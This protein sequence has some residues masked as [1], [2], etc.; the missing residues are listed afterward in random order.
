MRIV[1][2][3][4]FVL[5]CCA[6]FAS[7]SKAQSKPLTAQDRAAY[8]NSGLSS[9]QGSTQAQREDFLR[10]ESE[11]HPYSYR[12]TKEYKA[13]SP[14]QRR[15]MEQAQ[16]RNRAALNAMR[17]QRSSCPAGKSCATSAR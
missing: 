6:L 5:M 11:A 12:D 13:A 10:R 9:P 4:F 17:R 8:P 2:S 1:K 15:L 16:A 3:T 14:A 7:T